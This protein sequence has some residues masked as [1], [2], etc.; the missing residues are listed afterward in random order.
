MVNELKDKYDFE[1]HIVGD[2]YLRNDI[3]NKIKEYNLED[4]VKLLGIRTDIPNLLN[5]SHC[6]VMPSL[7]EGLPIVI[8]EAGASSLPVISTPMGSIPSVIN[9]QNGYLSDLENFKNN[10]IY[11]L[12]NY[13]EAKA[14]GINLFKDIIKTYS[15]DSV[16]LEHE[17]IYKGLV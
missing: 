5:Q 12:E 14:K 9:K 15:I 1:L 13:E 10:M 3:E 8:L 17:K 11:V 16:V 6:L 7:W 4:R 2:S